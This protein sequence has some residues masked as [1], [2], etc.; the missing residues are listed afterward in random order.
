MTLEEAIKK[1]TTLA[2]EMEMFE[3]K[4]DAKAVKLGIE[5]L[6]FRQRLEKAATKHPYRLLPG[7]TKEVK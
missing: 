6:K 4:P 2:V 3:N 7:E 5:A 1:L